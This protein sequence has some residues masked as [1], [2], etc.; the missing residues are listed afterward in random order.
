MP[1]YSSRVS[2]EKG[3]AREYLAA[4]IVKTLV[5]VPHTLAP[6]VA[7]GLGEEG[8]QLG[9]IQLPCTRVLALSK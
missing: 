9:L 1:L 5:E 2:V 3:M 8:C 4:L 7:R 6:E